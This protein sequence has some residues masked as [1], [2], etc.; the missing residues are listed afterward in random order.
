M[1][2]Q[3]SSVVRHG[4]NKMQHERLGYKVSSSSKLPFFS[5]VF[6]FILLISPS[7]LLSHIHYHQHTILQVTSVFIC[8]RQY[9][10][11]QFLSV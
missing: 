10:W 7:L 1:D 2:F 9:L 11:L 5:F 3:L 6:Y 8:E 4:T